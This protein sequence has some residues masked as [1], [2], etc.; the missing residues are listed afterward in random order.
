MTLALAQETVPAPTGLRR[1]PPSRFNRARRRA[2]AIIAAVLAAVVGVVVAFGLT[3]WPGFNGDEGIY[4]SQSWSVL[5]GSIEAYTYSYDHPFLGW[6]LVAPFEWLAER[7][8]ITG[9]GMAV[10]DARAVMVLLAVVDAA[11]LYG[12]ARRLGLRRVVAAFTVLAWGLSPLTVSFA[13]QVYLDNMAL[14]FLLGA[15]HLALDPAR[16][17]WVY[18]AAGSVFAVGVL[19]KE[20]TLLY[21]PVLLYIVVQRTVGQLRVMA[22]ASMVTCSMAVILLYPLFALLRGEFFPGSGH[23]SLWSEQIWAQLFSRAG[24]GS[25]WD[26]GSARFAL[27]DSWF[28][29]D[30]WL[31]VAGLTGAVLM[32]AVKRMRPVVVTVLISAAVVGKSSGYLPGMY[33]ISVLPFLALCIGGVIESLSGARGTGRRWTGRRVVGLVVLAALIAAMAPEYGSGIRREATVN[34]VTPSQHADR[35]AIAHIPR[36]A[37]VLVDPIFYVDLINAG[38]RHQWR[39]AIAYYQ[40]DLD[41]ESLKK[42]PGAWRDLD[43]V[44]V[45]PAMRDQISGKSVALPRTAAAIAHS[46]VVAAFGRGDQQVQIRKIIHTPTTAAFPQKVSS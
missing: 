8:D 11:L 12:L 20:T 31:P 24:S 19:S 22:L 32:L 43:Y 13:R 23:V 42:L 4:T 3:G 27:V 39:G 5:H 25:L 29:L 28:H 21:L 40:F 17:Q 14:P 36:N 30:W 41:P 46:R 34:L 6:A 15:L 45:T 7:I 1:V 44:L 35:Y 37:N 33:I 10:L 18:V 2:D 38:F 26:V 16:R 9:T